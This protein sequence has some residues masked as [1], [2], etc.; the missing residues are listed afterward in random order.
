MAIKEC[1]VFLQ[2]GQASLSCLMQI[3]ETE[4]APTF[5]RWW[6]S[7]LTGLTIQSGIPP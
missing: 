3:P 6:L 4:C 7:G 2:E 5:K 1:I